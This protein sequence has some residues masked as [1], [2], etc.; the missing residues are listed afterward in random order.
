MNEERTGGSGT[1]GPAMAPF[2]LWTQWMQANMGAMTAAPGASVPWL[3]SP[4]V[5]T[6]EDTKD[7]PSGT[8]PCS[9]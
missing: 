2:D 7:L 4:G 9:P 1:M 3:A 5:D 6:R 8:T